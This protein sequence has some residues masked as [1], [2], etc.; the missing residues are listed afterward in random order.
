MNSRFLLLCFCLL[1]ALPTIGCGGSGGEAKIDPS[2]I[3]AYTAEDEKKAEDYEAQLEKERQ[4]QYGS[5]N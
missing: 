3:D 5:G 2:K 1:V 4:E